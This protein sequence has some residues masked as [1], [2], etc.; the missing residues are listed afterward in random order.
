MAVANVL[1]KESDDIFIA[2]AL[3]DMVL[4]RNQVN[5]RGHQ[6]N[7]KVINLSLG[8]D[9]IS[10]SLRQKINTA[11]ENGILVVTSAGNSGFEDD[12][13]AQTIK[14]PGRSAL[15]L[16]VG[17]CNDRN[18]L[19]QYSSLGFEAPSRSGEPDAED[20]KPD[21]IAPGGSEFHTEI[22]CVDS[23][24][25]DG[26]LSADKQ[27]RDYR[28]ISGT[29]ASSPFVAGCAALVIDA[30]QQ[31]RLSEGVSASA[32][33]DYDSNQDVRFVKMVLCATATETGL[34]REDA[35]DLFA[36][37]LQRAAP[38]PL[39]FPA[40]KDPYEGY[41]VVNADA[42][43]EAVYLDYLWGQEVSDSFGES[44]ED[45]RAWARTIPIASRGP[46]EFRLTNPETGDFDLYVYSSDPSPSGTPLLLAY[47]TEEGLG[48][49]ETIDMTF[50][51][52]TTAL[53]IIKRV[54]GSG[55][56]SFIGN[57]I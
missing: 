44:P 10:S 34:V 36:P 7:I 21:V 25:A 23:G 55:M 53:L 3:D 22:M 28:S 19:T 32:I 13:E 49:H 18:Q 42:A 14:D 47:S 9:E 2:Q 50:G 1:E 38:G 15:A 12:P 31:R 20:Y 8:L 46:Y 40:G 30:L 4:R 45:R 39:G 35:N 57:G 17:A 29:S 5:D 56:F 11:A 6:L 52:S 24:D 16:T 33:W 37:P 26:F 51:E 27:W 41:G 43:V 54:S 48:V